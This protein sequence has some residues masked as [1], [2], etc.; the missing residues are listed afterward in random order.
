LKVKCKCQFQ[1][2]SSTSKPFSQ[3]F[4][5]QRKG[6]KMKKIAIALMTLGI[7]GAPALAENLSAQDVQS[8]EDHLDQR[9]A[10][11]YMGDDEVLLKPAKVEVG[12]GTGGN[13][14]YVCIS[15]NARG[16]RF[17]A[18]GYDF[19]RVFSRAERRCLR[20]SFRCQT[21]CFVR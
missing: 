13:A 9:A 21:Q 11:G 12:V 17:R 18:S 10:Q 7:C 8:I 2:D 19:G 1:F 16:Q 6:S 14:M 20:N 15:R 4:N 5:Q 3:A